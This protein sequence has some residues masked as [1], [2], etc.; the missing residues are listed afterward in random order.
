[1]SF[2]R[3]RSK[4]ASQTSKQCQLAEARGIAHGIRLSRSAYFGDISV[5][6]KID[7][8]YCSFNCCFF[9]HI[10]NLKMIIFTAKIGLKTHS[11]SAILKT[12]RKIKKPPLSKK[13]PPSNGK[14]L[15]SPRGLFKGNTVSDESLLSSCLS[16]WKSKRSQ[17]I[18]N[19]YYF[20]TFSGVNIAR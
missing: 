18:G 4:I 9:R 17:S 11:S 8:I 14:N 2:R 20:C 16:S 7:V 13:R 10:Y 12:F 15:K 5:V 19:K 3:A 6:E 1:M